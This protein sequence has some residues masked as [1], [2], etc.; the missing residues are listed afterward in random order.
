MRTNN[1]KIG[2]FSIDSDFIYEEPERAAEIFALLRAV[3]VRAEVLLHNRT[4]EYIAVSERFK[5]VEAG[6]EPLFYT[7]T[8]KQDDDGRVNCVEV[9]PK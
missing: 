7:L 6:A 8:I 3:V 4:I 2:K 9:N 5:E 1:L